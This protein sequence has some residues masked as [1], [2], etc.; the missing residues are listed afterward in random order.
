MVFIIPSVYSSPPSSR[1]VNTDVILCSCSTKLLPLQKK[2]PRTTKRDSWRAWLSHQ[3]YW[4]YHIKNL[5]K[6][7]RWGIKKNRTNLIKTILYEDRKKILFA[8]LIILLVFGGIG[9][10]L[11]FG[12]RM[13]N[14][15][16][17]GHIGEIPHQADMNAS[18]APTPATRNSYVRCSW[19][20]KAAR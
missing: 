5:P 4:P 13:S 12:S 14:P 9:L 19:N 1:L 8:F 2:C 3:T 18:P 15:K 17:Y 11:F 10:W 20:P 16:N 6:P 7:F